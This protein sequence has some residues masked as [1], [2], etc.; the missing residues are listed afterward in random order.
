MKYKVEVV[1]S[2]WQT[3]EVEAVSKD[4]AEVLA[5]DAFDITKARMGDGEVYDTQLVFE[6]TLEEAAFM[7][8]YL[9]N[10]ASATQDNVLYFLEHKKDEKDHDEWWWTSVM[11]AWLVWQ[12]AIRFNKG[13]TK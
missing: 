5:L 10:V 9:R 6:P 13:E 3:I 11:D 2:Y 7:E 8:A 4:F 12:D 1:M